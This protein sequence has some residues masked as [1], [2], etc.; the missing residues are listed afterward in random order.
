MSFPVFIGHVHF[1]FSDLSTC[2]LCPVFLLEYASFLTEFSC[3]VCFAFVYQMPQVG[4][5]VYYQRFLGAYN[6]KWELILEENENALKGYLIDH[7]IIGKARKLDVE[8]RAALREAGQTNSQKPHCRNCSVGPA[9][10]GPRHPLLAPQ[11]TLIPEIWSVCH[12]T[13]LSA[14]PDRCPRPGHPGCLQYSLHPSC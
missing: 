11:L 3:S 9:S 13:E 14:V 12:K 4:F 7:R 6:R 5:P 10:T 2:V 1:L 8:K